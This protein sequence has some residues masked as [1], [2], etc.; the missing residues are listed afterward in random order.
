MITILIPLRNEYENLKEIESTFSANFK[1]IDHEIILIN[2]FSSDNTLI[3]AKEISNINS[4]FIV[5]NNKKKGL[6]GAINLGIENAKGD[7]ICIMM[8][9]LSDDLN[10]LKKYY[11]LI[12]E[13]NIDAIFGSRFMKNSKVSGYPRNKM[14]LNRIFNFL[15]KIVFFNSYN[16]YTNAFKIYKA[17]MLKSLLPLISE[18]FNVFLEIPLKTISRGYSFKVVPISWTGRKKGTAKFRIKELRSKYI[19]TLLYCLIEKLLLKK[20]K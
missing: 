15:V 11:S 13:N 12:K 16:D 6:G 5:L 19:F 17:N 9:D 3:K 20:K 7:F 14:L 8:A 2:D 18:S 1:N 10:D 4:N